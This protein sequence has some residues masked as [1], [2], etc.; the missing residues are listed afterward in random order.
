IISPCI[1]SARPWMRTMPSA[2]EVTVP[3]LRASAD[4][5][6]FSMRVLISSLISDGLS[7][8]VAMF[9]SNVGRAWARHHGRRARGPPGECQSVCEC[10][11]HALQLAAQRAVDD[12]VAGVDHR[13]ADQALVDRGLDLDL[14]SE[15]AAQGGHQ[16][17]Q[18]RRRELGRRGDP[19]P[20]DLV[21][22]G[23]QLLV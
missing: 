9:V 23:A 20:D 16:A 6:T 5:P 21:R 8:V 11:L 13:T 4:R 3:S 22:L 19:G 10:V 17:F 1:T 18:L 2:T 15:A 14:A 12:G 7:C